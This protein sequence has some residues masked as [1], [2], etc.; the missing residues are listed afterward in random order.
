MKKTFGNVIGAITGRPA[1]YAID[2]E[3]DYEEDARPAPRRAKGKNNSSRR[4]R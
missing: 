4:S 3:D 1:E 2:D